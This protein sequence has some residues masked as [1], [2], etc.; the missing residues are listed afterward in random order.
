MLGLGIRGRIILKRVME[1]ETE[2]V[3]SF[4]LESTSGLCLQRVSFLIRWRSAGS[5]KRLRF[6][7]SGN[8]DILHYNSVD[9][10]VCLEYLLI[11][12]GLLV[13]G[14]VENFV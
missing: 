10:P 13:V 4:D 14:K 2:G 3:D 7:V 12:T 6:G 1:V 11:K 8:E 5:E 9:K